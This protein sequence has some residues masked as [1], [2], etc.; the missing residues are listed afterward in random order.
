VLLKDAVGQIKSFDDD[1]V[2]W[3][4]PGDDGWSGETEIRL[5][6]GRAEPESEGSTPLR[7]LLEV[8]LAQE[9]LDVWSAWRDGTMPTTEEAVAALVHYAT[10]DAYLSPG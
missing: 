5:L 8:W 4:L 10:H 7:R 9:V 6:S 3:G 1:L 2:I